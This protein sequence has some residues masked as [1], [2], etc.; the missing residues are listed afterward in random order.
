[1]RDVFDMRV[2]VVSQYYPPEGP[3]AFYSASVAQQMTL[4]GHDVRVLTGFPNYPTGLLFPGYV[5]KGRQRETAL[6]VE[7]LRVPLYLDHSQSAIRRMANY[8]SFGLSSALSAQWGR[9]TDVIYVY[10]TQMTAALGPW[11]WSFFGGAPYVL[12]VQDL[13]PDSIT[14]SSLVRSGAF[15]RIVDIILNPWI[16]SVYRR[17]A[18]VIGIAPTMVETLASRGV[19]RSKL[20]LVFNWTDEAGL[21]DVAHA[22][23]DTPKREETSIIFAGNIGVLQDLEVAVRAA[24]QAADA[25]VWLDIIGDGVALEEVRSLANRLDAKNVRFHGQVPRHDMRDRYARAD[26]S[27][28]TLKDLPAFRG[29]IPSK[30][31]SS[32]AHGLPIVTSVQGDVRAIVEESGVGF[33]ADAE[34][35]ESLEH[36]FRQA[37][38]TRGS[39]S[40]DMARRARAIY[41]DRFSQDVAIASIERVLITA[42]NG[43]QASGRRHQGTRRRADSD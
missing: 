28:V 29:T 15:A 39:A 36:A 43:D 27:L 24:H 14:G 13:W 8:I 34:S 1:M 6:G 35:V 11:L 16:R 7:I 3:A 32:M 20:E 2:L 5:M 9:G 4:R 37:A 26:Y 21:R 38:A 23:V 12:H 22:P 42:A 17:S 41:V 30:L 33:T 19:D 40:H 18:A 10:A 31:Q 25:G